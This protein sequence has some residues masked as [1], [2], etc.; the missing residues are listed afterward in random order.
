LSTKDCSHCK[1]TIETSR[2]LHQEK[3]ALVSLVFQRVSHL[4][5]ELA[6]LKDRFIQEYTQIF[7]ANRDQLIRKII[8]VDDSVQLRVLMFAEKRKGQEDPSYSEEVVS[9]LAKMKIAELCSNYQVAIELDPMFSHL[10]EIVLKDTQIRS[11]IQEFTESVVKKRID[12]EKKHAEETSRALRLI[13]TTQDSK[14]LQS[15]KSIGESKSEQSESTKFFVC[16]REKCPGAMCIACN[17]RFDNKDAIF[18]HV[19]LSQEEVELYLEVIDILAKASTRVCPICQ[20]PGMKD[21]ACKSFV[22]LQ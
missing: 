18:N 6:K 2:K 9:A 14:L 8:A 22:R 16:K 12:L 19:C 7:M 20:F 11:Q 21:L 10:Q 13:E 5:Q 15:A 3:Q 4:Q 1:S 17:Q